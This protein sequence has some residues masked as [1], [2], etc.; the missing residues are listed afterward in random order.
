MLNE[1]RN[2]Y[3]FWCLFHQKSY[4]HFE[5]KERIFSSLYLN[6]VAQFLPIV[7]LDTYLLHGNNALNMSNSIQLDYRQNSA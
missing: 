7:L 1:G 3:S 2:N 6:C 4:K 5:N